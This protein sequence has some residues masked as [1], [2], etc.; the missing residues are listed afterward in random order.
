MSFLQIGGANLVGIAIYLA[1]CLAAIATALR[2]PKSVRHGRVVWLIVAALFLGLALFRL[3]NGEEAIRQAL[4]GYLLAE[5][6]YE[7]RR[8]FQT[9][10]VFACMGFAGLA[11]FWAIIRFAHWPVWR[12]VVAASLGSLGVLYCLRIISWH[13]VD[14][15]LYASLGPL[16]FNHV[17]ELLPIVVI[18]H[19]GWVAHW[20]PSLRMKRRMR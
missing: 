8:T 12:I 11:A 18:W 13:N 6:E 16:H 7:G 5:H 9:L 20:R 2:L 3:G 14:R 17:L 4:R 15:L 10:A 19:A 1:T